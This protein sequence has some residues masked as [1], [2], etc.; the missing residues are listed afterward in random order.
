LGIFAA[1]VACCCG[2]CGLLLW[3]GSTKP[4]ALTN[5]SV[6]RQGQSVRIAVDYHLKGGSPILGFTE[7]VVEGDGWEH[8]EPAFAGIRVPVTG[9]ITAQ[10]GP[11]NNRPREAGRVAIYLET[12]S[13]R[14]DMGR[15]SNVVRATIPAAAP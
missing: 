15:S 2:G 4:I 7:L 9:R 12:A 11:Q 1:T 10:V 6:E 14:G 5:P 13:P 3:A 8:R